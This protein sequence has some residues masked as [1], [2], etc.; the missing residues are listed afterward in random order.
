MHQVCAARINKVL[1]MVRRRR[2]DGGKKF[3]PHPL[4]YRKTH[5]NARGV[6]EVVNYN[7][8]KVYNVFTFEVAMCEE[9]FERARTAE[10]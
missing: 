10:R 5:P 6:E 8:N 2:R 9:S 3:I 7:N 4:I 1:S